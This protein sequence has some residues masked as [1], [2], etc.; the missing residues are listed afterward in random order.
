VTENFTRAGHQQHERYLK[1]NYILTNT[2]FNIP[3]LTINGKTANK[4]Q[5]KWNAFADNSKQVFT[6]ISDV[7]STFTFTTDKP[8]ESYKLLR[9]CLDCPPSQTMQSNW[10]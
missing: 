6:A 1:D 8:G 4:I 5:D 7:D 3:P 9:N 2:N 10:A